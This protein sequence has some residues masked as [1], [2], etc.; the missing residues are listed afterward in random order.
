MAFDREEAEIGAAG[1][2]LCIQVLYT[3]KDMA[4]F[5]GKLQAHAR[6]K[7]LVVLSENPP[8]FQA[9][10][11]W[12]GVH[13]QQRFRLPCLIELM[14]VLWEM[15]IFSDLEMLPPQEPRGFENRERALQQMRPRLLV[16][17]GSDG[18]RRL[19][20]TLA[21]MLEEVGSRYKL[22]GVPPFRPTLV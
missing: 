22:P 17:P 12:P 9:H 3:V 11:L 21:D 13:G 8:Q 7:V 16:A 19:E 15:D 5:V 10:P 2:V 20:E 18:D 4:P 14:Q 1:I 6:E